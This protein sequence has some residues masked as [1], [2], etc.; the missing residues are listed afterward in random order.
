MDFTGEIIKGS[1]FLM[2]GL[3]II[4]GSA[5]L[6]LKHGR[7]LER[8]DNAKHNDKEYERMQ[9]IHTANSAMSASQ[10]LDWLRRQQKK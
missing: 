4:A 1:L 10:R 9:K 6:L 3:A 2:G 7:A 5:F 8:V